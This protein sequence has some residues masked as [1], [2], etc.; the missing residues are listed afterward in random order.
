MATLTP[1]LRLEI[2]KAGEEPVR[3][4]DPETHTEYVILKAVVYRQLQ[5]LANPQEID[6]SFRESGNRNS[7]HLPASQVDA[8]FAGS[9]ARSSS[10]EEPDHDEQITLFLSTV[11]SLARAGESDRGI[12]HIFEQFEDLFE[13]ARF[14]VCDAIIERID[15]GKIDATLMIGFLVATL[16]AK[17]RIRSRPDYYAAVRKKLVEQ[18]GKEQAE[19][20]LRGIE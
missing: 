20:L 10:S 19:R 4:E 18:R 1:E 17:D 12:D 13:T 8:T 15:V 9:F 14:D 5:A 16:I 6:S 11:Y 7:L 3:I 2:E